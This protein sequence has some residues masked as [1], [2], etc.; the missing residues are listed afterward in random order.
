MPPVR[1]V[2]LSL[3]LSEVV[4][5]PDGLRRACCPNCDEPIDLHQ[6]EQ[7]A[8][9]HLLGVCGACGAWYLLSWRPGSSQG[10]M[11]QLP[12]FASIELAKES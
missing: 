4:T 10:F 9:S 5:C 12:D 7:E 2:R 3:R 6:P 11:L 1:D 8:P